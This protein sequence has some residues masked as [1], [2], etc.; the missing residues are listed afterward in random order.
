MKKP[1]E[2]LK[3][4]SKSQTK[5]KLPLP[6]YINIPNNK[7][8]DI[9]TIKKYDIHKLNSLLDDLVK[10][11]LESD[12]IIQGL[13]EKINA[14]KR[15]NNFLQKEIAT[16]SKE[17]NDIN[18]QNKKIRNEQDYK[19]K[20]KKIENKYKNNMNNL[21]MINIKDKYNQEICKNKEIR[22]N[23]IKIKQEINLYK[24]KLI[25]LES[26]LNNTNSLIEKEGEEM[27]KF[28]NEL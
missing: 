27:K 25:E 4:K 18:K 19:K 17:N 2:K 14:K 24:N 22:E 15:E 11:D 6:N 7:N 23:I 10:K 16:M 20:E 3:S 12:L 1:S 5:Y 13:K 9:N 28:L 8:K 26:I 21:N